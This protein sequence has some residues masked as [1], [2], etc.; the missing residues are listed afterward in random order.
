[1]STPYR[2]GDRV[3]VTVTDV[4]PFGAFVATETGL[5]GLVRGAQATVGDVITVTLTEVDE[6]LRRFAA[7]LA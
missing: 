3:A 7:A 2:V 4:L 6:S 1:M 5:V